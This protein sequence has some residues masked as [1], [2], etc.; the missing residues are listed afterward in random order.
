MVNFG[1]FPLAAGDTF[2][3]CFLVSFGGSLLAL[4]TVNALG[5]KTNL[6]IG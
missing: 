2:T 1:N 3:I 5:R 6:I 4:Y